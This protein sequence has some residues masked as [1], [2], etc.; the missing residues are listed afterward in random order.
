MKVLATLLFLAACSADVEQHAHPQPPA[1]APQSAALAS[2]DREF[3]EQASQGNTAE[4][5]LGAITTTHAARAEVIAFGQMMVRDHSAANAKLAAIAASKRISLPT[6]LG[7]HQAAYDRVVEKKRESFDRDFVRVMV[8]EHQQA[9]EL[10]RS[11]AANGADAQLK[12]YAAATLPVIESHF[13]QAQTLA[14]AFGKSQ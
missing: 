3:L 8:E 11:E 1:Q 13:Q 14:S 5:A 10:F 7:E 9:A 4:I 2:Q 12:A 6:D